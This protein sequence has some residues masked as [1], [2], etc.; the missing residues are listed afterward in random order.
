MKNM[1][2][3]GLRSAKGTSERRNLRGVS[4]S[5]GPESTCQVGK[6]RDVNVHWSRT[7][8]CCQKE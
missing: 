7:K 1:L 5:K 4:L 6:S 3:R 2:D 8:E